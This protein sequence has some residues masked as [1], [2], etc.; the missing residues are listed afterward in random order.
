MVGRQRQLDEIPSDEIQLNEIALHE[1][2]YSAL[3]YGRIKV[4]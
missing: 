1:K 4:A 2:Q 3:A